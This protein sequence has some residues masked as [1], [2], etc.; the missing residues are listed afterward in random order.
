LAITNGYCTFDE[1]QAWTQIAGLTKTSLVEQV[2]TGVSRAI[3]EYCQ[4][5]FWKNGTV[6]APVTRTF[7]ACDPY[8]LDLGAR[9]D[10]VSATSLATDEAG[11][12]TFETVWAASDYQLLPFNRPAGYPYTSVDAIASRTFPVRR[13]NTGRRDR[14]QISGVWGWETIPAVVNQAC[15][16]KAAKVFTR[17]QSPQGV[18][19]IGDFVIRVSRQEDPD[20]VDLL[21]G[22]E[23]NAV[24]GL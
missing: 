8:A 22:V 11:D 23:H 2:I 21:D 5:Y 24:H 19:G 7:E 4:R 17:H 9:G 18:V 6:E 16:I 13:G 14:V 12:G 20:V 1:F 3:D 15:L 10:L